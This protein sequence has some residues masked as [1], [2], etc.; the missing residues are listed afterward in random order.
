ML[1]P[2]GY[3]ER[4]EMA[5]NKAM[6]AQQRASDAEGRVKSIVDRL[7]EDEKRSVQIPNDI[8]TANRDI[9]RAKTQGEEAST[10]FLF[11]EK[12]IRATKLMQEQ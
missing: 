2:G 7:P 3:S 10:K 9:I 6:G 1:A 11:E 5:A 4:A 8:N 12:N